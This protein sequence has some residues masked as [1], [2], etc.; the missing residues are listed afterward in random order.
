MDAEIAEDPKH[1]MVLFPSDNSVLLDDFLASL[2]QNAAA[3]K[4]D[5]YAGD[6]QQCAKVKVGGNMICMITVKEC[7]QGMLY[8]STIEA[9]SD[10]PVEQVIVVDGTWSQAR[11]L[12]RRFPPDITRVRLN[13]NALVTSAELELSSPMRCQV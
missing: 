11:R 12:Q 5:P 2:P 9:N 3:P 10:S 7:V 13:P 6:I 4:S 1:T 8:V